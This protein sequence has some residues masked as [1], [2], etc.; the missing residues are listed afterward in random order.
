MVSLWQLAWMTMGYVRQASV[1]NMLLTAFSL[2]QSE[3]QLAEPKQ[4]SKLISRRL[5]E[6]SEPACSIETG[7]FL[8]QYVDG[9]IS[10][11][12]GYVLIPLAR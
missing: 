4:Q 10:L 2:F 8:I 1:V 7:N 9:S 5:T 6:K 12:G 11:F 3:Q